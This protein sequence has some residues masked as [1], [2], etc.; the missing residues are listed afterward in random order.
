[1][2]EK[3]KDVPPPERRKQHIIGERPILTV[4]EIVEDHAFD[5]YCQVSLACSHVWSP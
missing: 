3:T 2:G 4:S 5:I 1:M